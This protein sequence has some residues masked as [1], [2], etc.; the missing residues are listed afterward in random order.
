MSNHQIWKDDITNRFPALTSLSD[1]VV[2]DGYIATAIISG[3]TT[4]SAWQMS[5]WDAWINLRG[6]LLQGLERPLPELTTTQRDALTGMMAG[7]PLF[8]KTNGRIEVWSGTEWMG[9]GGSGPSAGANSAFGAMYENNPAGTDI[10][11]S[12]AYGGWVS[13]TEGSLSSDGIITFVGD[14]TADRLLIGPGGAGIYM[15]SFHASLTSSG[16]KDITAA[17]HRNGIELVE[18]KMTSTGD[19]NKL[20]HMAS[21]GPIELAN[22]NYIDLRF[23]SETADTVS[24]RH[25]NVNLVRLEIS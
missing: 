1:A 5:L 3:V 22:T 23:K 9:A 19:N 24:L 4:N 6:Q 15:A 16:R 21:E 20:I 12:A 11:V 13:A 2:G 18:V 14:T 7:T 25:A 10:S 17:I 8:N